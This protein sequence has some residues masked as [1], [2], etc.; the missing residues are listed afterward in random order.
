M[1]IVTKDNFL[2]LFMNVYMKLNLKTSLKR[3]S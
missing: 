1:E 2:S 3:N